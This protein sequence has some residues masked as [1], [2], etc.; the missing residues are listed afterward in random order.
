MAQLVERM[1]VNHKVRGSNPRGGAPK[2]LVFYSP[3][4]SKKALSWLS[5]SLLF[6]CFNP[7]SSR[8]PRRHQWF[9]GKISRCHRG[10]PGSIPGWC[11]VLVGSFLVVVWS[12][13]TLRNWLSTLPKRFVDEKKLTANAPLMNRYS[14]RCPPHS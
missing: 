1:A 8:H 7:P 10:A 12:C 13:M 6:I 9:S 5:V 4:G 3:V 2:F 14:W 11:K